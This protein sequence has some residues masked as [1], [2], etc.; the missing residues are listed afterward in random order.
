VVLAGDAFP[1]DDQAVAYMS[2]GHEEGGLVL[3]SFRPDWEPRALLPVLGDATGL[4]ATGYL[5]AGPDRFVPMGRA[6]ERS[7][8]VDSASVRAAAVGAALLVLHGLDA[9]TDAWGRSLAGGGTP[10]LVWPLDAA[11]AA[12]VGVGAGPPE[13]GEW[14]ASP[15][16]RPSPLS[17][18]LAG[19]R[20]EDLPP[21]AG[22]LPLDGAPSSGVPLDA[23]LGGSG[24]ARPAVV[25]DASG[26]GRRAVVLATGFWRWDARGGAARDAYRRLW[27]GIGGWLL[28]QDPARAAGDVRPERW[29]GPAGRS[30]AW[31]VPP[32]AP[33]TLALEVRDS[34]GTVVSD[35]TLTSGS[36]A[37]TPPLP[38]GTYR[39]VARAGD[40]VLGEG[41]FDVETRS[42]ELL[43]RPRAPDVP[44]S[45]ARS[46]DPAARSG[47]PLR[48]APWPYLLVLLLLCVEWVGRRRTGLR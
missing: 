10:A 7:R 25:L 8:P 21:L 22:L 23:R 40:D 2:A 37:F 20:L 44:S 19:L 14:Y 13:P 1:S 12:A 43:H 47:H 39:Y 5:R 24:P 4:R 31:W 27:S 38:P 35:T 18:D 17:G 29:V 32:G 28:G 30:V 42:E 48:T 26:A 41:R 34:A 36:E 46:G 15:D 11:G 6:V 45:T 9:R 3:V 33:D 16:V